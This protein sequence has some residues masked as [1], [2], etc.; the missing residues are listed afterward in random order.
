MNFALIE[1]ELNIKLPSFYKNTVSDY[2][3][4]KKDELDFVEDNLVRD[5]K[6][7]IENNTNLRENGFFEN[8][9]SSNF[10]AIGHDGFGN[11]IFLNLVSSDEKIYYADHDH[12][13]DLDINDLEGLEYSSSMEEYIVTRGAF[14]EKFSLP[15]KSITYQVIIF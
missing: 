11:Y 1:L 3:F 9:W 13:Y 5:E 4:Q 15:Y 12:D 7:V 6:W 10:I 14:R 2:P 8:N